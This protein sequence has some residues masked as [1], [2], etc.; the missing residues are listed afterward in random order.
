MWYSRFNQFLKECIPEV[1]KTWLG[2]N[3][4]GKTQPKKKKKKI[5]SKL[6]GSSHNHHVYRS[7]FSHDDP[8]ILKEDLMTIDRTFKKYEQ[9]RFK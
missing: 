2:L 1:V 6:N 9:P 7:I 4:Y 3:S 5:Y 8:E